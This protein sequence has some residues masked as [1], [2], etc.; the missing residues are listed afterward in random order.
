MKSPHSYGVTGMKR[1]RDRT[2]SNYKPNKNMSTIQWKRLLK[3][4]NKQISEFHKQTIIKISKGE[5]MVN[6]DLKGPISPLKANH[7]P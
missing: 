1:R 6:Y 2:N 5:T 4:T 7:D 3:T